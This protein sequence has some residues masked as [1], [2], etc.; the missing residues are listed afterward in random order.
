MTCDVTQ[1]NWSYCKRNDVRLM[2]EPPWA[3]M[4]LNEAEG[5]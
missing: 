3:L 5:K 4:R 1:R 2:A